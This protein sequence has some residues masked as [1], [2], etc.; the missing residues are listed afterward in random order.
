MYQFMIYKAYLEKI[1]IIFNIKL[2]ISLLYGMIMNKNKCLFT[3]GK[4]FMNFIFL[5][6]Q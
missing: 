4:Y 2:I 3:V 1:K 5:Y 6:F